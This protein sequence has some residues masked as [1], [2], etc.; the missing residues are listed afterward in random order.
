M[1]E[2]IAFDLYKEYLT[3]KKAQ[4]FFGIIADE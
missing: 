3:E 2:T 1:A 4:E